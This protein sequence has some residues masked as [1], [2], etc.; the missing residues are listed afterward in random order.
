MTRD[1]SSITSSKRWVSGVRKWQFYCKSSKRWV[2]LKSQKL[3]DVHN[4]W[5][6]P[7]WRW[8]K[9]V[10]SLITDHCYTIKK[11]C[12]FA[13]FIRLLE[14]KQPTVSSLAVCSLLGFTM[15]NYASFLLHYGLQADVKWHLSYSDSEAERK[16]KKKFHYCVQI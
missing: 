16:K 12:Q 4:T 9:Y 1:H 6:V 14:L 11:L 13:N 7:Y 10:Y 5:M 15:R 3:D 8:N 2:G